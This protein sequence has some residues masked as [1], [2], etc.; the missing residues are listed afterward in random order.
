LTAVVT[1]GGQTIDLYKNGQLVTDIYSSILASS[2]ITYNYPNFSIGIRDPL[3]VYYIR[4]PFTGNIGFVEIYNHAL[5][6]SE[7]TYNFNATKAKYN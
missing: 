7:I 5:S 6:A 4:D 1:N 2:T 3:A